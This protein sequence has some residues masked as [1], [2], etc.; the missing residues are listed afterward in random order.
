MASLPLA[1]DKDVIR[2]GY[3]SVVRNPKYGMVRVIMNCLGPY[4]AN[5]YLFVET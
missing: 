2:R 5:I 4:P 1:L 3:L